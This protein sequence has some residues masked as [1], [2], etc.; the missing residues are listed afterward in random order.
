MLNFYGILT[1]T[2]AREQPDR[3]MHPSQLCAVDYPLIVCGNKKLR[4]KKN[5]E[6]S[7]SVIAIINAYQFYCI[8]EDCCEQKNGFEHD[9]YSH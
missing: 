1:L 5:C 6:T 9:E 4:N 7:K 3:R 2:V 8:Y